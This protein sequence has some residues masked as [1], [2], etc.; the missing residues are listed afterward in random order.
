MLRSD[1][2]REHPYLPQIRLLLQAAMVIFVFTVVVGIL[3]GTDIVEFGHPTLLTHV[4]TGTLGWITTSVFAA[5]L[6]LFGGARKAG[7]RHSLARWLPPATV[8]MVVAY[9]LAFMTTSGSG[10]PT[11]GGFVLL[12]IIGWVAWILASARDVVW[13]VPRLGI[14][15]AAVTATTGG[16]LGVLLGVMIATGSSILPGEAFASHPATMVIGFLVPV[17]MALSEWHLRPELLDER[18]GPLGWTQIGL[19]FV[20][21]LCVTVGLLADSTPLVALSLPFEIVG[22]GILLYRLWPGLRRVTLAEGSSSLL[23]APTPLWLA[24]NILMFV[25]LIA[26]YAGDLGSAPVGQ[27]LAVDH[28]MFIGV[29]S[30]SLFA[31][32]RAASGEVR[33]SAVRVL[34]WT[35][36]V[37]LAGFVVGLIFEVTILK[38]ISTPI[39]GLG[40]LHGVVLFTRALQGWGS[41]PAAP[42]DARTT[43]GTSSN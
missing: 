1:R 2:L 6:W 42:A 43:P 41:R 18:A 38:Q 8:V 7:W 33:P 23:A 27:I 5:A 40:I 30:N 4:H 12:T 26:R 25:Y 29:M 14:V 13:S 35:M 11:I 3:N 28:M 19:P 16:L 10:R 21:G 31:Q 32:V 20:G 9:N 22:V 15:A 17:G 37:G 39:M 24:V 36:N 34:F